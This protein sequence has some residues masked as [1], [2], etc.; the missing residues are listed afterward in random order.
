MCTDS[1]VQICSS[2]FTQ[3]RL[4]VRVRFNVLLVCRDLF[5]YRKLRF[6]FSSSHVFF[7]LFTRSW[8]SCNGNT[9]SSSSLRHR[10]RP[11]SPVRRSLCSRDATTITSC[12]FHRSCLQRT[13]NTGTPA[14]PPA[15]RSPGQG[16]GSGRGGGHCIRSGVR[17]ATFA[18]HWAR[19]HRRGQPAGH[20]T[21]PA[22]WLTLA[23]ASGGHRGGYRLPRAASAG[24]ASSGRAPGMW[25][26]VP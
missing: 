1:S 18:I 19:G 12:S 4:I 26:C 23:L 2:M 6:P 5:I 10:S 11:A 21:R 3:P 13:K 24:R 9:F 16:R 20:K 17:P 15:S 14:A 8:H 25:R 22:A 7:S